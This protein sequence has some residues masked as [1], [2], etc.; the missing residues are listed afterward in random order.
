MPAAQTR[1]VTGRNLVRAQTT[2]DEVSLHIEVS[3]PKDEFDDG[4][5]RLSA[6][7]LSDLQKTLDHHTGHHVQLLRSSSHAGSD[8]ADDLASSPRNMEQAKERGLEDATKHLFKRK[9]SE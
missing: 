9:Y 8:A 4:Y 6:A 5:D 2:F 3:M 7:S 1:L